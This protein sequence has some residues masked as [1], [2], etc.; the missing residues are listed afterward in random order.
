M[1]TMREKTK[2]VLFIALLAFVGLIFFDWGMQK[3][4][5]GGGRGA[6]GPVLGKVNGHD[7]TGDDYRRTRTMVL[8]NFEARSGRS[9][10][11]ADNDAIEEEVWISL[12]RNSLMQQEIDRFGIKFT[13]AEILELLKTNPPQ[14]IRAGFTD[15]NGN[16]D[17]AAY[18]RALL[19]PQMAGQ[20][21][22]VEAYLRASMPAEKLQNYVAMNAHVTN[23]ELR[24]RFLDRNEKV[25]VAYVA[26]TP[27]RIE[28]EDGAITDADL[29]AWYDAHP[30]DYR[31]RESAVLEYVE[32]P[33]TP[34]AEDSLDVRKDL[35]DTRD[36]IVEGADFAEE[37]KALSDDGS[38]ER[39][40][41]LGFI[42]KGDMVPEFEQM[43]WATNVGE[44]SPVFQTPFGYHILKVEELKNEGGEEIR[45]VR[46]ILMRVE[47]S[48]YTL[49]DAE[50]A[51][52]NLVEDLGGGKNLKAAAEKAGL[53]VQTTD[54]F[55]K[56]TAIPGIGLNRAAM[57]FAFTA[58][59]G[60][61]TPQKI[62]DDN[63][64]YLFKLVERRPPGMIPFED[65][66]VTVEAAV[67]QD[68][69]RALAKKKL[70]DA[71]AANPESLEK[72]AQA[73]GGEV[74]TTI[75]FS[76]EAFVPG[77]GRR[78]GFV[79]EAFQLA[80]GQR[81]GLVDSDRGFYVMQ[82]VQQIPADEAAFVEQKDRLREEL[83]VEKRQ[84]YVQAWL[85]KLIQEAD[86]VDMRSGE[87]VKW[88]PDPALFQY[89]AEA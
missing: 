23:A 65:A 37:A 36:A 70:T 86:V 74:D 45:H 1:S 48:N 47:A 9:A 79:A 85:E 83:F 13:D 66:K 46:H 82:V 19:D 41:D 58:Q 87:S 72:L 69:Q 50:D 10:T 55:E 26:S 5:G 15:A 11:A 12:V 71:L 59:P 43:A 56:D 67:R 49:R 31:T 44:V 62:E 8:Q 52:D 42:S 24:Q 77:V 81:S 75:E 33:K 18:Q 53:T 39:G 27:A 25:R 61:V 54:P 88:T 78:N 63:G 68:K 32:I 7:I 22:G 40:G 30:D 89:S 21:A 80:E 14:E 57:R 29:K 34:S 84:A 51:I 20:W 60:A 6:S 64:Y 35:E 73:M 16:F 2:V 76:R 4:S 38:A 17:A 3:S 28:L